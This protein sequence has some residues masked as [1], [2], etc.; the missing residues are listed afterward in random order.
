[1]RIYGHSAIFIQPGRRGSNK[2]LRE[3]G[4]KG[5]RVSETHITCLNG[6]N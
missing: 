2:E 5:M 3:S 6:L 1:M 4:G